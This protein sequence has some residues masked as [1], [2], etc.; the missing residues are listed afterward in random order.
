MLNTHAM[1]I[2][3]ASAEQFALRRTCCRLGGKL[4]IGDSRRCRVYPGNM[5]CPV[6][7]V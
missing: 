4:N 1:G 3:A 5:S 2:A 7:V 6:S